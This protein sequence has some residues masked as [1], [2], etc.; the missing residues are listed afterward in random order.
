MSKRLKKSGTMVVSAEVILNYIKINVS[1]NF[2]LII[3]Q[4]GKNY[5]KRS[6]G[7]EKFNHIVKMNN[8]IDKEEGA[9]P[10]VNSPNTSDSTEEIVSP[11]TKKVK[12]SKH[13]TMIATANESKEILKN[14][15]IDQDAKT[16]MQSNQINSLIKPKTKLSKHSTMNATLKVNKDDEFLFSLNLFAHKILKQES[17]Y[18]LKDS[19][20]DQDAKT[21]NQ[22]KEI[23]NLTSKKAKAKKTAN[24]KVN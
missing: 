20:I 6:W 19:E 14:V 9:K 5:L 22:S 10:S 13:S 23:L 16:R 15:K 11:V 18:V 7:E 17:E 2:K 1:F 12:L 24:T 4:E 3:N 21:R 8:L